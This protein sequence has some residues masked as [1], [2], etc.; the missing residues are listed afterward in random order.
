MTHSGV[1]DTSISSSSDL[2]PKPISLSDFQDTLSA[3][4]AISPADTAIWVNQTT[5]ELLKARLPHATGP[6]TRHLMDLEIFIDESLPDRT[7][8]SGRWVRNSD[9][10]EGK[11]G[12][13]KSVR[14]RYTI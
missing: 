13:L 8:E 1:T 9:F 2:H 3:V 14:H 4:K 10:E 12:L 6:R 11:M 5:L 7:V